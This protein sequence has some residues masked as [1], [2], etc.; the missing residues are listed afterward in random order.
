MKTGTPVEAREIAI[1]GGTGL[2]RMQ[3]L[4]NLGHE[5]VTTPYGEASGPLTHGR[6]WG[7]PIVFLPRHGYG[8]TIPPHKVNYRANLWALH[9]VGIRQVIAVNAVGLI[10][11]DLQ[12][13][14]LILPDQM[15]DY[16]HGREH[17]YFDGD[18]K[19]VEH[20][21][22]TEP[23]CQR[24]RQ[25][26]CKAAR[27]GG[28]QLVESACYG[29]TQGP[30]LETTAEIHR[31]ER[32]GCDLVGMTGMPEAALARELGLDYVCVALGVNRAAGRG[33]SGIHAEMEQFL[34]IAMGRLIRLL[35]LALDIISKESTASVRE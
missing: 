2:A 9:N 24:L 1:I 28:L 5:L 11:D 16:T 30:R 27:S 22:F 4:E 7:H 19:G 8:H 29:A 34:D 21:D 26:F 10:R 17:T 3:E 14:D 15:I 13:G 35:P 25:A 33:A 20:V 12:P 31:M 18:S 32:D 23:Y 6:L